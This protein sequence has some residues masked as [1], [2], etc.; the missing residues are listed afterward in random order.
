MLEQP[1][2][3]NKEFL[4]IRI[5][6]SWFLEKAALPSA[7]CF[8][9]R[10]TQENIVHRITLGRVPWLISGPACRA[11]CRHRSYWV[12]PTWEDGPGEPS[13]SQ[14]QHGAQ[15]GWA[16]PGHFVTVVTPHLSSCLWQ[17]R[18]W[19][20]LKLNVT[21]RTVSFRICPHFPSSVPRQHLCKC[22]KMSLFGPSWFPGSLASI[23]SWF[24]PLSFGDLLYLVAMTWPLPKADRNATSGPAPQHF[25]YN[26]LEHFSGGSDGKESACNVGDSGS[27]PGSRR[28][29]G[30]G[31]G[32]SFQYFCRGNPTDRGAWWA[33]VYRVTKNWTWL[34]Y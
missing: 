9:Y 33:T 22:S 6:L 14:C 30:E 11:F 1:N 26:T 25:V 29:P 23:S 4:S 28:S 34:S 15:S 24:I 27:V 5:K 18:S 16:T 3:V 21:Q 10:H 32:N 17:D 20:L 12:W 8:L 31:N 7:C 2:T 13:A 19:L